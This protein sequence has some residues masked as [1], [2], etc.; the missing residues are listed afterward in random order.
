M[1][2]RQINHIQ[3]TYDDITL[4]I[5]KAI[6]ADRTLVVESDR[7]LAHLI[8]ESTIRDFRAYGEGIS[9]HATVWTVQTG[10][11]TEHAY[12]NL[13]LDTLNEFL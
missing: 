11:S 6:D 2:A 1:L 10:G 8:D 9:G 5:S 12:F 3:E 7:W 4:A 13:P